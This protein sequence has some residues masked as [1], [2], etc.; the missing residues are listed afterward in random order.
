LQQLSALVDDLWQQHTII[1][2][3]DREATEDPPPVWPAEDTHVPGSTRAAKDAIR[4][5]GLF[6]DDGDL[7]TPFRLLKLVMDYW[8]A[9]WFWPI[10][11]ASSCPVGSSGGWRPAPSSKA[12]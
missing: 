2:A 10:R 7:A 6:N 9:L 4:K 8:C 1:L 3:R 12:L 11:T 5:C